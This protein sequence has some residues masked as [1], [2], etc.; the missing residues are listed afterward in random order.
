MTCSNTVTTFIVTIQSLSLQSLS[1]PKLSLSTLF[2][3]SLELQELSLQSLPLIKV[4]FCRPCNPPSVTPNLVILTTRRGPI[5]IVICSISSSPSQVQCR[6][7]SVHVRLRAAGDWGSGLWELHV[8]YWDEMTHSPHY[9][10]RSGFA[11]ADK[12]DDILDICG[13]TRS[14]RAC[15]WR[16]GECIRLLYY[17]K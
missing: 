11:L 16:L 17:G 12:T 4:D 13:T 1:L 10:I 7:L 2:L 14:N 9:E 15:A 3:M 6:P 8:Y 5:C